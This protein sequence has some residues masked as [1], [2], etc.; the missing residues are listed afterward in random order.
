MAYQTDF[1][2]ELNSQPHHFMREIFTDER[3]DE[4]IR[5]HLSEADDVI[6]EADLQNIVTVMTPATM[7][8][9]Q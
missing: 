5:K 6:T 7:A 8:H 1:R 2:P 4:R 3:T 9:A